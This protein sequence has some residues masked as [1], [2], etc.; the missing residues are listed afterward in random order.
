LALALCCSAW[1]LVAGTS[2][3]EEPSPG[4]SPQPS[5]QPSNS[6]SPRLTPLA[7]AAFIEKDLS[8]LVDESEELA[9]LSESHLRNTIA[10]EPKLK[11]LQQEVDGLQIDYASLWDMY[12]T[13][14]KSSEQAASSATKTIEAGAVALTRMT[15]SRGRWRTAAVV[16]G[17]LAAGGWGAWAAGTF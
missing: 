4:I 9:R 16:L 15:C 3:A 13:L 14:E 2:W 12:V 6:E 11:T 1:L 5:A 17:V 10:E 8:L 7:T